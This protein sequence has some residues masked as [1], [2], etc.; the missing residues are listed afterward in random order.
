MLNPY[1]H[2]G[3]PKQALGG[4][5]YEGSTKICQRCET[6]DHQIG[7]PKPTAQASTSA[8]KATTSALSFRPSSK[9]FSFLP[10]FS[11]T[12]KAIWQHLSRKRAIFLNS[13]LPQPRVVIAGE[14]M[15]TPPGDNAEASPCTQLRFN[16]IEAASQTFSTLPPVSPCGRT[17]QRTKWLS[18]PSLAIL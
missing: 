7:Y 8:L 11:C 14:P 1:T 16:D 10:F 15:R 6:H 2:N 18:V 4:W 13:S 9:S 5:A 3:L 17:S 12:D